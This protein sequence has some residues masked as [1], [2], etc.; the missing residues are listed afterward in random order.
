MKIVVFRHEK[1]RLKT[2]P[3][4]WQTATGKSTCLP[5][6]YLAELLTDAHYYC[7][8]LETVLMDLALHRQIRQ[9]I[10]LPTTAIVIIITVPV[11]LAW[12]SP[13]FRYR[14]ILADR[15]RRITLMNERQKQNT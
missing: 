13:L 12:P 14:E 15:R 5:S 3:E 6:A 10:P 11:L 2:G 4:E 9:I 7:N 1:S 8:S